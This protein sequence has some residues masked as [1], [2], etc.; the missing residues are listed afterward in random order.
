MLI[1]VRASLDKIEG[2]R[3]ESFQNEEIELFLNK[4]QFRLL[5]DLINKNFQQ[6]TIRF[7]WGRGFQT[8]NQ[9]T[10]LWNIGDKTTNVNFP[11]GMYYLVAA[12]GTVII[13]VPDELYS[14]RGTSDK[15]M[16]EITDP[17][18][19]TNPKTS[20]EQIDI[21]E[22]GT[23]NDQEQNVFYGMN[24]R[25][26]KAELI[27]SGLRLYRGEKYIVSNVTFDYWQK[28]SAIEVSSN[29]ATSWPTSANEKIVDYTVEYMRLSIEDPSYAANV[30]DFNIRTQ[31]A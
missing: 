8:T 18:S 29:N 28:P 30:Q 14:P 3:N 1:S 16:D 12:R 2:F 9:Q 17:N 6:G 15:C 27:G 26:P 19:I 4:S 10:A 24:Y 22:T 31:N 13:S 21:Q 25:S 23:V 5:D 20:I 11:S 7:E